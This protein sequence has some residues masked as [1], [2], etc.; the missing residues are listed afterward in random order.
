MRVTDRETT[1]IRVREI[2]GVGSRSEIRAENVSGRIW[3]DLES[4][5]QNWKHERSFEGVEIR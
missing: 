4:E 2:C 1:A 3:H 5:F